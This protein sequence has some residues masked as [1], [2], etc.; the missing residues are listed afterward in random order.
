MA[1]RT[2]GPETSLV[3]ILLGVT[4]DARLRCS[5]IGFILVTLLAIDLHV[6]S[7]KRIASYRV[8]EMVRIEEV[9]FPRFGRMAHRTIR[10]QP[11]LMCV[12]LGMACHASGRRAAMQAVHVACFTIERGMLPIE[13]E[14]G[15]C[16]VELVEARERDVRSLMFAVA[17]NTVS[18]GELPVQANSARDVITDFIMA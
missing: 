4:R 9:C 17:L 15:A 16:M 3:H 14:C 18:V 13:M 1:L 7:S 6:L 11:T 2:V 5:P 10:P 8:V 12:G